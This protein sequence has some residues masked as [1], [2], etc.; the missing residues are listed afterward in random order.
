MKNIFRVLLVSGVLA[1]TWPA[2]M[3]AYADLPTEGYSDGLNEEEIVSAGAKS[4]YDNIAIFKGSNYA[5]VRSEAGTS[6]DVVGKIFEDAA[7][8]ILET[9]DG[10]DGEWY[11]I[12]S[13]KVTGYIKAEYFIT[14]EEAEA[15]AG[16][17]GLSIATVASQTSLRLRQAASTDS[18]ILDLLSPKEE[19]EVIG[20]E[21]DFAKI[22]VDEDLTGYV[23]KEFIK[24]RVQFKHAMTTE[25]E[26]EKA[27]RDAQLRE[28][29]EAAMASMNAAIEE[30]DSEVQQQN[31]GEGPVAGQEA[32]PPDA[33]ADQKP[34]TDQNPE[35][36]S[37]NVVS[38]ADNAAGGTMKGPGGGDGTGRSRSSSGQAAVTNA[39]RSAIVAYAKQFIGNPYVYGGTSL[40]NGADCSGFTMSIFSHFGI[41]T[42][43]SSR[44]QAAKGREIPVSDIQPGDLLFYASGSTINHVALYIGD[45]QI[46]HASTAKTGIKYAEYNYRTPCK[47]V[48]FLD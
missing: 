9:V 25:E 45:G 14:G 27:A 29:A 1:V 6:G 42:G 32:A 48:T 17:V 23:S 18:E 15:K 24:T 41:S 44:D 47:A 13:G 39:T 26:A 30:A 35:T 10:E 36:A 12:R 22:R 7:A 11:K 46:I 8:D 40:T 16:Q 43:R 33:S 2:G 19:Y 37:S 21:G 38:A 5:N 4:D 34:T 20:E 28:E 3:T 31:D